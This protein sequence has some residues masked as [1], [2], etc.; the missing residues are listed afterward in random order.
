MTAIQITPLG[1]VGETGAL[2][3]M[4]YDCGD[5][6]ILVDCGVTFGDASLPGVNVI[7]PDFSY[8]DGYRSK[9]KALVLTH[10]HED[11][12]GA[13]A[14]FLKRFPVPVYA[15]DFTRGV[16]QGKITEMGLQNTDVRE[17]KYNESLTLGSCK[18]DPIY[19][20]HSILDAAGL[21]ISSDTTRIMHLTDFK[22]DHASPDGRVTDLARFKK[23]GEQGIDA[24]LL[25]STNVFSPGWTDSESAVRANLF[26]EFTK[27]Q[28][29][30][31]ACLF[32]S[33]MYRVQSL[34]ECARITGRKIALT[35]R[36]TKEYYRIA[37][38]LDRL[39]LEGLE[40]YDVEDISRFPDE[41]ILVIAT[42]SQAEARSVLS[43]MANGMFGPFQIK[44]G[45]TVIMSSK[46]IPGNEGEILT[47]LN[48]IALQGAKIISEGMELPIHCSGHAKREELKEVIRLLKPKHFIPI[49]G[50]YR[51]LQEHADL[52]RGEGLSQNQ[53]HIILNGDCVAISPDGV[54]ILSHRDVGRVYY[55][56]NPQHEVQEEAVR[57]RRK[58]AFNGLVAASVV[59]SRA[60]SRVLP[61]VTLKSEGLYGGT[62]EKTTLE[63]L[64]QRLIDLLTDQDKTDR[65]KLEKFLKVEIR[66]YYKNLFDERPEVL[67]LINQI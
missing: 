1:G 62:L 17:L 67:V 11:H 52:A 12:V 47:M 20:N 16:L 66:Q 26:Q 29:R 60:Q 56:E 23:I 53:V 7:T 2:N 5:T 18:I 22:I 45:D 9:I 21:L 49:H 35:G 61:V 31:I 65:T 4:L 55:G 13:S 3:C 34:F 38:S 28:G 8:L 58:M 48:L 19:I 40:F 64:E 63:N 30:I 59:F 46:M 32:A 54:K 25:D 14:Y 15:T 24:L 41:E 36:S 27:I 10:G 57:R 51:H 6:A 37:A 44:S 39:K 50:E 43:R 42:G 33:N